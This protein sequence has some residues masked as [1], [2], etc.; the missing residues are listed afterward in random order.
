MKRLLLLFGVLS[1]I[2]H[3]LLADSDVS[4]D[5]QIVP[6]ISLVKTCPPKSEES[7]CDKQNNSSSVQ[8]FSS[9]KTNYVL[10][11][12]RIDPEFDDRSSL[13]LKF[14]ISIQQ[15]LMELWGFKLSIGYTQ[16]SFWQAYNQEKSSPF[17]ESNYNPELFVRSPEVSTWGINWKVIFGYEHESNGKSLPYSRSWDRIYSRV[18]VHFDSIHL[19]YKYWYRIP[20]KEKKDEEDPRG[21]DNPDIHEYYG[22]NELTIDIYLGEALF[23]IFARANAIEKKGAYQ[24]DLSYPLPGK[25][26]YWYLQYWNGYGESLIDYNRN[27]SRAGIGIMITRP[28]I[29]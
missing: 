11:Y 9:Y 5:T 29:Y 4:M 3:P 20:E 21:D 27:L 19:D 10:P 6:E 7:S 22:Y 17:R 26:L 13:E 1:L 18:M 28:Q 8:Y 14:Q 16:K 24:V 23:S 2:G 15:A 12:S 25:H